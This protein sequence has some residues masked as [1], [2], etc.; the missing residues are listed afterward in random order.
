MIFNWK[1]KWWRQGESA[2]PGLAGLTAAGG[3]AVNPFL[4]LAK[5]VFNICQ[6]STPQ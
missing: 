1:G 4:F 5:D 3:I 2:G 6:S